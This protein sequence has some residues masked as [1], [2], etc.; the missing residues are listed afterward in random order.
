VRREGGRAGGSERGR[1]RHV[2]LLIRWQ[3]ERNRQKGRNDDR[4]GRR[5]GC[6]VKF[7]QGRE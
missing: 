1:E 7:K 3:G 2:A 4:E 5:E 6:G